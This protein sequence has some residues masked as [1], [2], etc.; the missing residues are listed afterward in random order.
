MHNFDY[1]TLAAL[2]CAL[3]YGFE[4]DDISTL[5]NLEKPY[6]YFSGLYDS[7]LYENKKSSHFQEIDER[8]Y[9]RYNSEIMFFSGHGYKDPNSDARG[10]GVSFS[11]TSLYLSEGGNE[12]HVS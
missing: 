4:Y 6:D 9:S 7:Y 11:N 2:N 5:K 1:A 10:F 3:Y 12:A 8:G